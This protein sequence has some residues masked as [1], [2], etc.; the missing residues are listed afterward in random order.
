MHTARDSP[1]LDD[2]ESGLLGAAL[3][4]SV[5]CKR[6]IHLF[7]QINGFLNH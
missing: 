5:A 7:L 4:W 2:D 1:F 6:Y 3:L